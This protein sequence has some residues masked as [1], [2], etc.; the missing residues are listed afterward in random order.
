MF[1]G[2]AARA[3]T[4]ALGAIR[5]KRARRSN[6]TASA[7]LAVLGGSV[8]CAGLLCDGLLWTGAAAAQPGPPT[9]FVRG[10]EQA[11]R[12]AVNASKKSSLRQRIGMQRGK[13]LLTS[14]DSGERIRGLERL[15]EDGSEEAVS[16]L[17]E[18]MEP[19]TA[20]RTDPQSRLI[21]VRLL[22][23]HAAEPDVQSVL[24]GVLGSVRAGAPESPLDA[25]S[26]AT[27]AMALA[28]AGSSD[29]LTPLVTAVIGGGATGRLARDAIMAH[30]PRALGP[31]GRSFKDM[32]PRVLTLLG[33]L[34]DPRVIGI[35]RKQLKRKTP[36]VKRAAVVA[37]AKLGDGS[38]ANTA[39]TWLKKKGDTAQ[40]VA[41]SEA[42]MLLDAPGAAAAI[43]SLL[44]A[45]RTRGAGLELAEASLSPALVPTLEAVLN[46]KVTAAER[47]RAA[48]IIAKIGG[49]DAARVLAK[50]LAKPGLAT[51]AA[52]GLARS[53]G[54]LATSALGK[55][56]AAAEPGAP[57][58]LIIRAGLVRH[59]MH[60]PSIAGLQAAVEAARASQDDADRA[61][62]AW[63]RVLLDGPA[64]IATLAAQDDDVI[65][66]AVASAA[67]TLGSRGI[68]ELDE[69]LVKAATGDV[70]SRRTI[71]MGAALLVESG[72]TRHVA[73][74]RLARWAE[75][76]STLAPLAALRLAARDSTL[77]RGRTEQLLGGTDPLVRL[78]VALGLGSS[79]ESDA[80]SLLIGAYR[81]ETDVRVRRAIVRAL[82]VRREKLRERTLTTARDLDPDPQVRALAASALKGRKLRLA[83]PPR[84]QQVAWISLRPNSEAERNASS[85]RPLMLIR[86]DGLALPTLS[87][88]DG[89]VLVGGLIETGEVSIQLSPVKPQP[90]KPKPVKPTPATP[91]TP[92]PA[93]T[94]ATPAPT[95]PAP[96]TTAPTSELAPEPPSAQP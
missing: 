60:G 94:P 23:A 92:T 38:V 35:C 12:D 43:A 24:E 40:Q 46:A 50:L 77:F 41:A 33:E 29:T 47:A 79:P 95:T 76:G 89:V 93:T 56:L 88:P 87:A 91:A 42:L 22:A 90:A 1:A 17:A 39:R 82:S 44:G 75:G 15:A 68:A 66:T 19:G 49:D 74:S 3:A 83:L 65:A 21:A 96:T 28:K 51:A 27:A 67:I 52:F 63:G 20:L 78:H 69:A 57:K 13:Q 55:A 14:S 10:V 5:P 62:G 70:P 59:I 80:V 84:G 45:A 34:G 48:A 61:L 71:A 25:L 26:R 9:P 73:T 85:G 37:L 2:V 36:A 81:F 18:A 32:S 86:S 58:R 16:A 4:A 54:R 64:S 7:A 30:P 8:L 11:V 72:A 53:H 6:G 31:L